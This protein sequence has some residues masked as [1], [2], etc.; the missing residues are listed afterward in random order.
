MPVM[1]SN[2]PWEGNTLVK[3][4]SGSDPL[5]PTILKDD[6]FLDEG[7]AERGDDG[8]GRPG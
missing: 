3:R 8:E 1:P 2:S 5:A 7:G 6:P 4:A